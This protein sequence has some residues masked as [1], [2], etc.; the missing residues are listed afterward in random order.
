[1]NTLDKYYKTPNHLYATQIFIPLRKSNESTK[2]FGVDG[3]VEAKRWIIVY[4]GMVTA[5]ES[6][7]FRFVGFADDF[8]MVR[9]NGENVLDASY[10]G[11]EL[12]T[13]ATEELAGNA[14]EA[15]PFKFGK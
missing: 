6:C 13:T 8:M 1:M 12:D 15:L 7:S 10:A 14:P 11:E 3:I 5:P 9:W 2:A 4:R